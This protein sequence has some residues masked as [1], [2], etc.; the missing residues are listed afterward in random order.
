MEFTKLS[1][2]IVISL[3][4]PV[5]LDKRR[6]GRQVNQPAMVHRLRFTDYDTPMMIYRDNHLPEH[7]PASD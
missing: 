4:S 1:N 2:F 7:I 3:M 6:C 5:D